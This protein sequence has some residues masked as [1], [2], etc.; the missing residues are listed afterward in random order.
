MDMRFLIYFEFSVIQRYGK[1]RCL[2]NCLNTIEPYGWSTNE[3]H[4]IGKVT[5]ADVKRQKYDIENYVN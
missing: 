5:I 2:E 3:I 4:G 1:L